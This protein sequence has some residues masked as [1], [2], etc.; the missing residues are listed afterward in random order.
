M[1]ISRLLIAIIVFILAHIN[2]GCHESK[3]NKLSYIY[4][5]KTYDSSNVSIINDLNYGI[6]NGDSMVMEA[7]LEEGSLDPRFRHDNPWL[8]LI[9][10]FSKDDS[11][12][13]TVLNHDANVWSVSTT[14][15][16]GSKIVK[17]PGDVYL[18]MKKI[19]KK[20]WRVVINRSKISIDTTLT[21]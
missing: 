18:M 17:N 11:L 13:S 12:I 15:M 9:V 10:E 19:D 5:I 3:D 2:Y 21:F 4:I 14:T 20:T 8:Y 1:Y 6:V 16:Y 7:A